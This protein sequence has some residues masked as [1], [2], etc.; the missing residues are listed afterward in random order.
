[1]KKILLFSSLLLT[2]SYG[3][4]INPVSYINPTG[5][6]FPILA[7]HAFRKDLANEKNFATLRECGFNMAFAWNEDTTCIPKIMTLSQEAGIKS[8]I[9]CPQTRIASEIPI[10]AQRYDRYEANAGYIL[11]DEPNVSQFEKMGQLIKAVHESAP[12]KLAYVNLLPNYATPQQ[13]VAED[14]RDYLEKFVNIAKPRFLS[15]DNYCII[16]ED[17]QLE[18]RP[19]YFENLE[20]AREI[21]N[22]YELPLWTFCLSTAHFDY[23]VPTEGQLLFE[24][25]TALAYGSKCIQ[26]YG[27]ATDEIAGKKL[28]TA[29]VDQEGHR[30]KIWYVIRKVNSEI[31]RVG[32]LLLHC[33]S[34]G[35]WHTGA[36][37]PT[38][39]VALKF[40]DLPGPFRKIVSGSAGVVV[41]HLSIENRNYLLI[42]NKDFSKRQKVKIEIDRPVTRITDSG[43]HI[44]TKNTSTTLKAGGWALYTY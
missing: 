37:I 38:G 28:V 29:P 17:G 26:Y 31:Q 5:K 6:D 42:V 10:L 22:K 11:W 41:G 9:N 15:Y 40:S 13:L 32:Q 1:M 3:F 39:T 16:K 20:I 4:S 34:M 36:N 24:A 18:L 43:R 21:C 33:K 19:G 7:Y 12:G 27:Y 8:F 30:R 25:F 2:F 35:V 44:Q 23:P 14:Y